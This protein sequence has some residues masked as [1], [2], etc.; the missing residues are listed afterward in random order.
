MSDDNELASLRDLSP[1]ASV[2]R[3]GPVECV[4]LPQAHLTTAAGTVVMDTVLC[5]TGQ[6]SY[7]TR[8]LLERQV[9][10]KQTLNWCQVSLL[11]RTWWTWSWNNIP[12][13]QPWLKIFAEHARLLR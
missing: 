7:T 1:Q 9:T 10:T 13:G 12:A 3:D 2:V 8:L 6:G 11:G 5:P 4:L